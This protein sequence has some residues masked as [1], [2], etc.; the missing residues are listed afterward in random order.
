MTMV[1]RHDIFSRYHICI[2]L[3]IG[4]TFWLIFVAALTRLVT[5]N[6]E[7]LSHICVEGE[8]LV[9][10]VRWNF[11]RLQFTST[12]AAG[13]KN[14]DSQC[15]FGSFFVLL[16]YFYALHLYRVTSSICQINNLYVTISAKLTNSGI[17]HRDLKVRVF[18]A[19]Y[20]EVRM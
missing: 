8:F 13:S 20:N 12:E 14:C 3:K 19:V 7:F 15:N 5:K 11:C 17:A 16:K 4:E 18:T 9:P 2:F 1:R 6:F 10:A